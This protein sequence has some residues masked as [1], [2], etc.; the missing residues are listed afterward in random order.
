ME[1]LKQKEN[2]EYNELPTFSG[3]RGLYIY[4][5]LVMKNNKIEMSRNVIWIK[6]PI[7]STVS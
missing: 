4:P 7:I 3:I 2:I 1:S 6:E 5:H